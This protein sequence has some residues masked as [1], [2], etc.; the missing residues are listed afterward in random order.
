MATGNPNVR[1]DPDYPMGWGCAWWWFIWLILII[2]FFGG[3]WWWGGW[4]GNPW[5]Q[6]RQA[7]V[8][9]QGNQPI[10]APQGQVATAPADLLGR[11][12][13]LSG[14]V[15]NV[16]D[17]HAF[18]LASTDGNGRDLLVVTP[19]SVT[20]NPAV[21]KGET[22]QVK[23]TVQRFDRTDFDQQGKVTLPQDTMQPY[24]GRP[25]ILASSVSAHTT[26]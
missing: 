14:K 22:V 21:K 5:G 23:G 7:A 9:A 2:I 25:A 13:T 3:G 1:R 11:T 17:S 19:S 10:S 18:T 4:Y 24:A 6:R 8:P 16:I 15:D 26:K 20:P 12:V